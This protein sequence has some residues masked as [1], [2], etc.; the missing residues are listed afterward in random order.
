MAGP[1][2][3]Q[4]ANRSCHD[5][6]DIETCRAQGRAMAKKPD[7]RRVTSGSVFPYRLTNANKAMVIM[8]FEA[9]GSSV[10]GPAAH[11]LGVVI[12]H[13]IQNNIDFNLR[14]E[15]GGS[16]FIKKVK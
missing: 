5:C 9:A 10:H 11:T 4:R 7:G 6:R 1:P 8:M 15:C 12:E 13:C 3:M 14:R 16:Y 2:C